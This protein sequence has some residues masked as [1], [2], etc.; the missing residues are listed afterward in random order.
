M[1]K[2]LLIN[3]PQTVCDGSI[4]RSTYFPIGLMYLGAV[5]RDICNVEILDCLLSEVETKEGNAVT[6]GLAFDDIK[7]AIAEKKP[8]IVGISVPFTAQYRNAERVALLTKEVD[9]KIVTVLGGPDPSVRYKAIL[10]NSYCN[11]CVV[12]EGEET[13]YEFVKAYSTAASVADIKGL[14]YKEAGVIKYEPRPFITDLDKLPFPAFDLVDM[15]RYLANENLYKNRSKIYQKSISI[16]TSR[17]CPYSCVFCSIRLH[18]GQKYRAHSPEYVLRLLRLCMSKYGITNFHFEDDNVSFDKVRFETIL[19]SIIKENLQIHWDTPNG[20]RIDS[21]NYNILEKM[22]QSGCVQVTLAIESGN[23]RVL[24]QVIKK[25][26][27][28]PYILE[29]VKYCRELKIPANAFYVIGFPGETIQEMKDTTALAVRLY[30]EF[31]LHPHLMVA[32]PLYGTE[33]YEICVREKLLKGN[34]TFEELAIATQTT[35]N[36]LIATADFSQDDIRGVIEEFTAAL[37]KEEGRKVLKNPKE[38]LKHPR[39]SLR[40]LRK[41]A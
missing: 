40:L 26:T 29:I 31:G 39:A 2:V 38:F 30:R 13:L 8:D 1:L 36:P 17:G 28:L 37:L 20:V 34:P 6:Y 21:L 16:I 11:Y 12:G 15:N 32:T 14:A 18:M 9:S 7:K 3:P 5:V 27:K 19:D 10:E 25:K 4:G 22:K 24:D 41:S 23:Q 35:G 33:L